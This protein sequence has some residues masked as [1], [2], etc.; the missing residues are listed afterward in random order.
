MKNKE[1]IISLKEFMTNHKL[2]AETIFG[3]NFNSNPN[4]HNSK[5]KQMYLIQLEQFIKQN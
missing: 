4:Y 1:K 5:Y 3:E 2:T